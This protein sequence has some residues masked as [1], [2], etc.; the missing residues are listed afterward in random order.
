MRGLSVRS[1]RERTWWITSLRF[2]PGFDR[3][4]TDFNAVRVLAPF[5]KKFKRITERDPAAR[6]PRSFVVRRLVTAP[7]VQ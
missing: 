2:S 1:K 3:G 5:I 7:F 6:V 4:K